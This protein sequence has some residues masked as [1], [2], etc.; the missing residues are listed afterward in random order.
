MNVL[1]ASNKYKDYG[2]KKD[3]R[4]FLAHG[5]A[6]NHVPDQELPAPLIISYETYVFDQTF[7]KSLW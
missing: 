7:P 1:N 5:K 2:M 4:L 6:L 3:V